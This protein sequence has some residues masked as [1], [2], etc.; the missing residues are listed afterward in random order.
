MG[1]YINKT[2]K[3]PLKP[4]QK[5]A[6]LIQQG[7]AKQIPEPACLVEQADVVCVVENGP[8][9]A[10]AFIYSPDELEGFKCQDGRPRT[11]LAM[12]KGMAAQMS[13]YNK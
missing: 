4:K 12:D 8:F 5:A 9:D 13:G 6:Q 3:G 11:W 7:Y 1:Y 10:A 2:P